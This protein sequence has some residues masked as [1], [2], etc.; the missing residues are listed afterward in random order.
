M[1]LL[2]GRYLQGFQHFSCCGGG[3]KGAEAFS[4]TMGSNE[5]WEQVNTEYESV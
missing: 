5:G 1:K 2:S 4:E 3:S